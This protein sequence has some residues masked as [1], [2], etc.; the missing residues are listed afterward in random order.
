M[1][2]TKHRSMFQ[3]HLLL[4][5]HGKSLTSS[6]LMGRWECWYPQTGDTAGL[7]K[8][9]QLAPLQGYDLGNNC[10]E[11]LIGSKFRFL[12]TWKFIQNEKRNGNKLQNKKAKIHLRH[13]NIQAKNST[14]FILTLSN[15]NTVLFL[16]ILSIYFKKSFYCA[17]VYVTQNLPF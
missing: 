1:S 15:M 7:A 10:Y 16:H 9:E 2:S 3:I 13:P 14:I 4:G 8:T 11:L 5:A 12:T 6:H 17:K